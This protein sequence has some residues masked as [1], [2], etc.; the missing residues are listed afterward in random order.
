MR[1][2]EVTRLSVHVDCQQIEFKLL[3][4]ANLCLLLYRQCFYIKNGFMQLLFKLHMFS[5][6][7]M[8]FELSEKLKYAK[9]RIYI[10]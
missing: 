8:V 2:T 4:N 3:P 9:T 1:R 5:V 6:R 10:R 7:C